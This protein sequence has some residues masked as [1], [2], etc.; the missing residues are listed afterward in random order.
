MFKNVDIAEVF[1]I[2][3]ILPMFGGIMGAMKMKGAER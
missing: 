3:E 1:L 2:S